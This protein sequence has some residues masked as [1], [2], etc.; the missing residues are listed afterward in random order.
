MRQALMQSLVKRIEEGHRLLELLER[1]K[2]RPLVGTVVLGV[3]LVAGLLSFFGAAW[4]TVAMA[5]PLIGGLAVLLWHLHQSQVK[6]VQQQAQQAMRTLG[7]EFPDAVQSWGGG[8]ALRNPDTVR[9]IVRSLGPPVR[10]AVAKADP[11]SLVPQDEQ[12]RREHLA[13][14]L[15]QVA[16]GHADLARFG[17]RKSLPLPLALALSL[18]LLGLPLGAAAAVSYYRHFGPWENDRSY[19]DHLGNPLSE[20]D[21]AVQTRLAVAASLLLLGMPA[22]AGAGGLWFVFFHPFFVGYNPNALPEFRY[23]PDAIYDYR[24]NNIGLSDYY[25]LTRK[26]E[27]EAIAVGVAVCALLT[28]LSAGLY[29]RGYGRRHA[30]ARRRLAAH[31]HELAAA[32]PVT[33]ENWGGAKALENRET[34]Q[35]LL[36]TVEPARP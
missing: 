6:A 2:S 4:H 36:R 8:P 26:T 5:V 31:V 34:V 9:E 23:N 30:E 13:D 19:Y 1:K 29:L 20:A 35:G 17:Q 7:E 33:V 11:P 16:Q 10:P 25:A 24:G 15:S 27:A 3:V 28:A 22:G 32:F 18:F 14:G 12:E 21:S